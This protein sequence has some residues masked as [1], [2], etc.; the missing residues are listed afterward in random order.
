MDTASRLLIVEEK[1]GVESSR[2]EAYLEEG[3][4]ARRCLHIR[5]LNVNI[6]I[7]GAISR[8]FA[9]MLGAAGI[10][11][12]PEISGLAEEV[13]EAYLQGTLFHGKFL[14]P[15]C[16]RRR[17]ECSEPHLGRK[18]CFKRDRGGAGSNRQKTET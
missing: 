10:N 18:G 5:G 9:R 15:G 6:L 13:L 11:V 1:N 12:I 3:D 7:C 14:M 16:R 4:L 2:L 17:S 8:P